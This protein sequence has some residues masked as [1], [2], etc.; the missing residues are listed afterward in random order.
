MVSRNFPKD[1]VEGRMP[2]NVRALTTTVSNPSG[3]SEGPY[4]NFNLATHVGDES[5][6]VQENRKIL[7][8]ILGVT[9]IFW[10]NQEHGTRCVQVEGVG[11]PSPLAD[12]AWTKKSGIALAVLT[13]DCVPIV[14][15]DKEGC[16][17]AIAHAGWRGIASGIVDQIVNSISATHLS[18]IV[19]W[20][21]PAIGKDYYVIDVEVREAISS[22][23]KGVDDFFVRTVSD[24]SKVKYYAD[25]SGIVSHRLLQ[26]GLKDISGGGICSA[27][28]RRFYSYR[29]DAVTGRMA[30]LVWRDK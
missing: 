5:R 13:A 27:S 11:T 30:T 4:A 7:S 6:A 16:S 24:Q 23:I 10:L 22:S 14:L 3:V 20:I 8:E 12:G 26:L 1:W 9:N 15:A 29:R 2:K 21:G 17:I 28:D 19:A 25:L 18:S